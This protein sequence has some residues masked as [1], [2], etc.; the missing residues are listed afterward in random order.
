MSQNIVLVSG[1]GAPTS[2]G[3]PDVTSYVHLLHAPRRI[4][5]IPIEIRNAEMGSMSQAIQSRLYPGSP[6]PYGAAQAV[7][8]PSVYGWSR[9][10]ACC[11]PVW[12][13]QLVG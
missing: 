7:R 6:G 13:R 10:R 5:S 1:E 11:G 2:V 8:I 12:G 3:E 9:W 4:F